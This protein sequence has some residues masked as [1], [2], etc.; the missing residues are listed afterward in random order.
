MQ[1]DLLTFSKQVGST[2][3]FP[4]NSVFSYF[5]L[6]VSNALQISPRW[7]A[8]VAIILGLILLW[9]AMRDFNKVFRFYWRFIHWCNQVT[10]ILI[11]LARSSR[12]KWRRGYSINRTWCLP[13]TVLL[14]WW[15]SVTTSQC[16]VT[17]TILR[18]L[19]AS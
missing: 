2:L 18:S 13:S 3:K 14:E 4:I 7:V 16:C 12:R 8:R 5:L 19:T 11:F 17:L 10:K 1:N 9:L 6:Y 15:V